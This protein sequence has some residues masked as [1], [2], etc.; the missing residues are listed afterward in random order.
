MLIGSMTVVKNRYRSVK[1]GSRGGTFYCEDTNTG[2]R[3]SLRTKDEAEAERLVHA[4][5]EAVRQPQ[6]NRRMGMA[7]LSAT[8]PDVVT[9]TWRFVMDEIIKDKEGPTLKRYQTALKDPA[10]KL[11][12]AKVLVETQA[13]DFLEVL[14]AGTVSTNVYLRRFQNYAVDMDWLPKRVLPK[15]L[16]PKIAY[17]DQR[18]ITWD[19]HQRILEREG[20]PERRD[21]YELCWYFGGSQSDIA[22]LQAGDLDYKRRGFSY[23]RLKTSK[24]ERLPHRPQSLEG[25]P[26]PSAHGLRCF[27]ISSTCAGGD[28]AT[29]FKQRCEG[30]GIAGVTLHS[31][32]YAWAERSADNGYP[33]RYAQRV[34]GQNSKM[35]HRAYAKK[36]P[37]AIAVS[38][39][40]RG[41]HAAGE[42]ERKDC[43]AR[44]GDRSPQSGIRLQ[45]NQQGRDTLM[46][47]LLWFVCCI[48]LF[49]GY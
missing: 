24:S 10:Y 32:R 21:F 33:E 25:H 13:A 44:N 46:T 49:D 37:E 3:K 7:Y 31:Y 17:K 9:R 20:N 11:I 18:G 5:N 16:F 48:H 12:E 28:R 47:C 22:S 2:K 15:R 23:D 38:G 27:P 35:V 39:G 1:V 43:R 26:A 8:D 30:L 6:I 29:E 36:G 42:G 4:K 34:L 40:I 41:G 19:E 45:T 14:R